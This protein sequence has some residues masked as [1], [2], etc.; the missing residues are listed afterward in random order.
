MTRGKPRS[1]SSTGRLQVDLKKR[2]HI[3]SPGPVH[4]DVSRSSSSRSASIINSRTT[5]QEEVDIYHD[6]LS[7]EAHR[8]TNKFFKRFREQEMRQRK[9]QKIGRSVGYDIDDI[10]EICRREL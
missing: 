5:P 8:K 3:E 10:F 2:Y 4:Y 1:S 7:V 6:T 9:I